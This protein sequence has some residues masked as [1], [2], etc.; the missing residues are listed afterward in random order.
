MKKNINATDYKIFLLSVKYLP[1]LSA[2]VLLAHAILVVCFNYD[3]IFRSTFGVSL[4]P[5]II[6][7]LAQKAFKFCYIH[8][9]L[10]WYCVFA[11][12]CISLHNLSLLYSTIVIG[13]I[14]FIV[15]IIHCIWDEHITIFIKKATSTDY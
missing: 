7:Y 4:I 14:L 10:L 6:V 11:D 9:I 2:L 12:F 13:V 1:I 3:S 15:F 5:A 8:K